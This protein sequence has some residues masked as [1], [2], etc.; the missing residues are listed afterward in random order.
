MER[1]VWM[2]RGD[3]IG[4]GDGSEKLDEKDR[5][6]RDSSL[7]DSMVVPFHRHCRVSPSRL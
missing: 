6:I 2:E 3:T 4:Y 5:G 1:T 7:H